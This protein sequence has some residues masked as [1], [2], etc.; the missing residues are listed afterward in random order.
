MNGK[1]RVDP[2]RRYVHVGYDHTVVGPRVVAI[3]APHSAP[4]KR[5]RRQAEEEGRLLDVTN[6]RRTRSIIVMDSNHV[7]L[8]A[9][10][11]ETL[12]RRAGGIKGEGAEE[13]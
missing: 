11:P 2:E 7:V 9:V 12:W 8:S 6:G 13:A 10:T 3:L 5:L 4:M 1:E